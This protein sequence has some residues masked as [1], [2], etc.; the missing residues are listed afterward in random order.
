MNRRRAFLLAVA[1]GALLAA[2]ATSQAMSADQIREIDREAAGYV[3][4]GKSAGMVIGI[5]ERGRPVFVRAYGLANLELGV[6][7]TPQTVFR[8]GSI[9]K[10][11][12]AAAIL[13][14]AERGQLQTSDKLSKY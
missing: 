4:A 13:R 1:F 14:L 6:R 10:Q 5:A 12:T 8:A 9:S 7:A 3:A 2:P 11:F